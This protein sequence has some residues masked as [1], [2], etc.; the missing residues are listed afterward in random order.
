MSQN[1]APQTVQMAGV[2]QKLVNIL[3]FNCPS[4]YECGGPAYAAQVS[5]DTILHLMGIGIAFLHKQQQRD[6]HQAEYEKHIWQEAVSSNSILKGLV[7]HKSQILGSALYSIMANI[8]EQDLR[9]SPEVTEE[10]LLM[11]LQYYFEKSGA[12]KEEFWNRL[13]KMDHDELIQ[14]EKGH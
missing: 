12:S 7:Q 4:N 10:A 14:L 1:A 6:S 13:Q 3:F 5:L 11:L 2:A 9:E 8:R